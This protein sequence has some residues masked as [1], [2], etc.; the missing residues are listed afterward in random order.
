MKKFKTHLVSINVDDTE[1]NKTVV[2]TLGELPYSTA[3]VEFNANKPE[4]K[5]KAINDTVTKISVTEI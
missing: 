4:G 5:I 3:L 1:N 2:W